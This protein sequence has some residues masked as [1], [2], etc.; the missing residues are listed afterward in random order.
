M[1]QRV[2]LFHKIKVLIS[3]C[4]PMCLFLELVA[5][6]SQKEAG[7]GRLQLCQRAERQREEAAGTGRAAGAE[8]QVCLFLT[9]SI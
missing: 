1:L 6:C 7:G 9:A 8:S 3:L 5:K 4:V 2:T